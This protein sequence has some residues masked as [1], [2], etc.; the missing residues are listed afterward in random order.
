MYISE[1]YLDQLEEGRI[2]EKSK[3]LLLGHMIRWHGTP[4]EKKERKEEKKAI[5]RNNKAESNK[6]ESGWD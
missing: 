4:E 5:K 6:H 2:K 3:D 1:Q